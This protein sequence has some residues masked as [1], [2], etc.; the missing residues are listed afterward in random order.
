[1]LSKVQLTRQDEFTRVNHCQ[2]KMKLW[3]VRTTMLLARRSLQN[4]SADG[5]QRV[6]IWELPTSAGFPA[7]SRSSR[8]SLSS[9]WEPATA[10]TALMGVLTARCSAN[11]SLLNYRHTHTHTDGPHQQQ[12][13]TTTDSISTADTTLIVVTDLDLANSQ[14]TRFST[15]IRTV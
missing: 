10:E 8:W 6:E 7:S 11:L 1:M 9:K 4:S 15:E 13:R 12:A 3:H 14:T 5:W 2:L